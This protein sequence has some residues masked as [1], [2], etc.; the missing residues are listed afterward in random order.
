MGLTGIAVKSERLIQARDLRAYGCRAM[1][2][3]C[4]KFPMHYLAKVGVEGSNPFAR[5]NFRSDGLDQ[6]PT[7]R[8]NTPQ[9][10]TRACAGRP[11]RYSRR[12]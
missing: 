4:S 7:H 12:A 1:V 9:R 8:F 6:V 5:S 11:R 2:G 3:D 10:A